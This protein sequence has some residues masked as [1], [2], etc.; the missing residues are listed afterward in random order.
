MLTV[1]QHHKRQRRRSLHQDLVAVLLEARC[2]K[3][4]LWGGWRTLPCLAARPAR[5]GAMYP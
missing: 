3:D 5:L 4:D 2:A 1:L